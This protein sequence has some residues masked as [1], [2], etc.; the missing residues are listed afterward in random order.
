M[1]S[2]LW[3]LP[4]SQL[5]PKSPPQATPGLLAWARPGKPAPSTSGHPQGTPL[6]V[7]LPPASARRRLGRAVR[8]RQL[9]SPRHRLLHPGT[10]RG[11]SRFS[12]E[13]TFVPLCKR[14]TCSF[15]D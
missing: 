12:E 11:V 8:S 4:V 13:S 5:L 3:L 15:H 7:P 2:S 9:A 10:T 14:S 1:T 6:L